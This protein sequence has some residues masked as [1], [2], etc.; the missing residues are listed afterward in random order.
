MHILNL[1]YRGIHTLCSWK[2]LINLQCCLLLVNIWTLFSV[3]PFFNTTSS[4]S[5]ICPKFISFLDV[6]NNL[7]FQRNIFPNLTL[8]SFNNFCQ[9]DIFLCLC[10]KYVRSF[11][12]NIRLG[13]HLCVQ[14]NRFFIKNKSNVWLVQNV[15][16]A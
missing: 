1:Y 9:Q 11:K 16:E 12:R 14:R 4:M 8:S 6:W 13:L 10:W 3:F 7:H 15:T 2:L 5:R